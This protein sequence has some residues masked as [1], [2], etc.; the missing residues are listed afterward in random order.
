MKTVRRAGLI[1]WL[2]AIS[3]RA[4]PSSSGPMFTRA[5]PGARL[6]PAYART[7]VGYGASFKK[8]VRSYYTSPLGFN[9][10]G[11]MLARWDNYVEID[12]N[13][14]DA[15]GI[16]VLKIHCRW[17]ENEIEM[18]KD[19]RENLLALFHKLGAEHVRVSARSC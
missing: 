7:M 2:T 12:K 4:T 6:F 5:V 9:T 8:T 1:S 16:P 10:R 14:V 17:S 19:A 3:S 18:A 13:V 11:E 15:W